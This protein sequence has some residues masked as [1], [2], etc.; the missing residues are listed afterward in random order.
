MKTIISETLDTV[1]AMEKYDAACKM[2]LSQKVILAWILKHCLEEFRNY[3]A[4]KIV[5]DFIEGDPQIDAVDVM[6]VIR[7]MNPENTEVKEG[8]ITGD[9]RFCMKTPQGNRWIVDVEAQRRFH[10]Q[11]SLT[12]RGSY[13]LGRMISAQRGT[14]FTDS[15]YEK[16]KKTFVIWICLEPPK[17]WN[18]VVTG[19]DVSEYS[20]L[21]EGTLPP[22]EYELISQ[23]IIGLGDPEAESATGVLRLLD[24]MFSENLDVE[25]K[26]QIMLSEFGIPMTKELEEGVSKMCNFSEAILERGMKRGME[27]GIVRGEGRLNALNE[28]LIEDG[29][30]DDLFRAI[31]DEMFRQGLYEEYGLVVVN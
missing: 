21:G 27:Q 25:K 28:K 24:V 6:P 31:K 3:S 7:G 4:D 8:R 18:N 13:Y 5:R 26:K 1:A 14:E 11:Y 9:I 29:R 12:K 22:E 15:H 10:P 20:I 2:L 30:V 19:Y 17:A 23:I 16:L